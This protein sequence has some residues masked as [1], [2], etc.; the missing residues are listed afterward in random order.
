MDALGGLGGCEK[1]RLS[2]VIEDRFRTG[3][4]GG[5]KSS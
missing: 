4:P 1:I 2:R 3:L 5:S